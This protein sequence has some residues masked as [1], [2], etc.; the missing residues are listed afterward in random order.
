VAADR[1]EVSVVIITRNRREELLRTLAEL[2]RLPERPAIIVVDNGSTDGSG[3]AV[4]A[5]HPQVRLVE[6]GRNAGAA[7]RNVGVRLAQTPYV[8]F[9][10]DDSWW[11]PGSLRRA[12][13]LFAAHS[14]LALIGGLVL[15]GPGRSVEP[16]CLAMAASPLPAE[17][18]LPGPPVLGFIACGAI[19]HRQRYLDAGG[20][21]ERYGVGGE[22]LPL[23]IELA[24]AGWG[25]AYVPEVIALH[26]PSPSRDRPG[27]QAIV[28]RNDL[29]VA[30]N[31]RPARIALAKTAGVV[32]RLPTDPAA[33]AGLAAAA[34]GAPGVLRDR[35]TVPPWLEHRLR[36]LDADRQPAKIT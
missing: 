2:A 8:A 28:V 7:A 17:P 33:R 9:A 21:H 26:Y 12:A 31:R 29:W 10:D 6:L 3:D 27:R 4:R 23:A 20:F 35:R 16:T 1:A 25:L 5:A 30:W 32:R 22:E 36:M 15:N 34:A 13:E 18:D 11:A 14:R 19:V 24:A